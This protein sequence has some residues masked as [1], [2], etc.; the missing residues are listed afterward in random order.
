VRKG[1]EHVEGACQ[2]AGGAIGHK[3]CGKVDRRPC[4]RREAV[5]RALRHTGERRLAEAGTRARIVGGR[6]PAAASDELAERHPLHREAGRRP[7]GIGLYVDPERGAA[8]EEQRRVERIRRPGGQRGR[9]AG[10]VRRKWRRDRVVA[11][12]AAA[13]RGRQRERQRRQD[14]QAAS[15]NVAAI[16]LRADTSTFRVLSRHSA[17]ASWR[18]ESCHLQSALSQCQSLA[19]R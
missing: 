1:A 2:G 19:A 17:P 12:A 6:R 13:A 15:S 11:V 7:A 5:R 18:S 9:S 16:R 4:T 14:R 10:A 8:E 3:V